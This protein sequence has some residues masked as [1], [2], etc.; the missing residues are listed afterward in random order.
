MTTA[1]ELERT[2]EL[3]SGPLLPL[4]PPKALTRRLPPLPTRP[5]PPPSPHAA[6][7]LA[8]GWTR[9]TLVVPAAFPRS[10]P[11]S[12]KKPD[13][14]ALDP[15]VPTATAGAAGSGQRADPN[16]GLEQVVRS[17]IDSF[18][19]PI[20]SEQVAAEKEAQEQLVVV[21]NRYRPAAARNSAPTA[22]RSPGLTLVLSHANGFYKEVWEPV[23]A[24]V[25]AQIEQR[26]SSLPVDEIWALDCA[27]QGDSAVLNDDVLGNAFNWADHGRDLVNVIAYYLDSPDLATTGSQ[28]GTTGGA[29]PRPADNVPAEIA[30]LDN[31]PLAG[32]GPSRPS[33]R[34][35]RKR[36]IVGI[37]HSLG[38]GATAFAATACPSLFSS[39]IFLDPVIVP[40]ELKTPR[41]M[42]S[43]TLAALKRRSTWQTRQD[44]KEAFLSK[45]FFRAWDPEVLDGYVR[46]GLHET[47]DGQV[48]L[49]TKP[50]YEALTFMD[51]LASASRRACVRLQSLPPTLPAHF[52]FADK[53]RSVLQEDWIEYILTRALPHATSTRVEGAGHLV[54]HEKPKETA[55]LIVDFLEKTYPRKS[56]RG[57]KL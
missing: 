39:V 17:Q 56:G 13:E 18:A 44:A 3:L 40:P 29:F 42:I 14:P 45:P 46:H 34:T 33:D 8:P 16:R 52:I 6:D 2:V 19:R 28:A 30:L 31:A 27:I 57:A 49:K 41:T 12:T 43:A 32:P 15:T 37:G 4:S 35:Y 1:A 36:L 54:V 53:D 38:G 20:T 47:N 48:A 55:Q 24:S 21:G 23:L 10:F 5:P 22:N 11:R 25:L 9:E 50:H 7:A 51:P 26:G